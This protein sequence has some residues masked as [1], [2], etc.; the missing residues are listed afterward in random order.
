MR[1]EFTLTK[2]PVPASRPRVTKFTTYYPKAHM[3]HKK[4]LED[5]LSAVEP[6][7]FVG[8]VSVKFKF[9]MPPYKTSD[10]PVHRADVD[11]LSKLPLDCMTDATVDGEKEGPK[12][13]WIDDCFVVDL[14]SLK[15]FANEG[16]EPHTVVAI[17]PISGPISD[18]VDQ[19][20]E[21]L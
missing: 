12:K 19:A 18:H 4:F 14:H 20:F 17:T 10:H 1:R 13:F 2:A 6:L 21:A 3:A 9:V 11:N 8:P 7:A 5:A 16:E 15:R